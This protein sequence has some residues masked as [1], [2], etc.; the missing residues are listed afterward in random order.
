MAGFGFRVMQLDTRTPQLV[1]AD[2]WVTDGILKFV[3]CGAE[4]NRD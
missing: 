4:A 1:G 2:L 3:D